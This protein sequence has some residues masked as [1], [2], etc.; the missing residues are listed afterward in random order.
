MRVYILVLLFC[1]QTQVAQEA[2][3]FPN[4]D[5]TVTVYTKAGGLIDTT[6]RQLA[7]SIEAESKAEIQTEH[8]QSVII[9]NHPGGAGLKALY[10]FL[11]QPA[12]GHNLLAITNS[13]I[14]QVLA[15]GKSDLLAELHFLA[16][17][18]KDYECLIVNRDS[19][20]TSLEKLQQLSSK[21]QL[22]WAG[23]AA[24][25]TDYRFA[26]KVQQALEIKGKWLPYASGKRGMLAV[27]GGHADVYV[28][29]PADAIGFDNLEILALAAPERLDAYPDTPTFAEL[30]LPQLTGEVLWRG[31]A[32]RRDTAADTINNLETLI[33]KAIGHKDWQ[34]YLASRSVEATFITSDQFAAVINTQLKEHKVVSAL[35]KSWD[36]Y[37][38]YYILLTL[39]GFI[40]LFA[41][42]G[43]DVTAVSFSSKLILLT[44][45]YLI[46]IPLL[47]Y[48]IATIVFVLCYGLLKGFSVPRILIS[49]GLWLL[50]IF[51]VFQK[52]LNIPVL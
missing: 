25:G 45:V 35:R 43:A 33:K 13:F 50:F 37:W 28:G 3:A 52:I 49:V 34:D 15:A 29:N 12:D 23:P 9:K 17:L 48:Y 4:K 10:H 22:I 8:S 47:G 1:L 7:K 30:N 2:H 20:I 44:G 46:A 36:E 51:V 26:R 27:A 24:G 18:A 41:F 42:S 5:I 40:L 31:F 32:V 6:A 19:G 14:S 39:L 21:K 38:H 11:E 16:L